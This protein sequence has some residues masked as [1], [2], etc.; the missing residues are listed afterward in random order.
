MYHSWTCL[1]AANII[2]KSFKTQ[3]SEF[4]APQA[5]VVGAPAP[6]ASMCRGCSSTPSLCHGCPST[7]S[8]CR[9]CPSTPSLCRG[10]LNTPSLCRGCP[11]TPSLC[12]GYPSTPSLCRGFPTQLHVARC[13]RK[14]YP[15]PVYHY[16]SRR[17]LRDHCYCRSCTTLPTVMVVTWPRVS[18]PMPRVGRCVTVS[19]AT[20]E[21]ARTNRLLGTTRRLNDPRTLWSRRCLRR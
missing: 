5:C 20:A 19:S 9:G 7:T 17:F 10:C 11:S 1:N 8:L 2:D 6:Q 12:R 13:L 16:N 3:S 15:A 14:P 18:R 4:P 21:A